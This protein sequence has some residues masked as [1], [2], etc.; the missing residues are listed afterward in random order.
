MESLAVEHLPRRNSNPQ[1]NDQSPMLY[2]LSDPVPQ[3]MST[4]ED[5]HMAIPSE[6][7]QTMG[8]AT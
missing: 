3:L 5:L 7:G 2:H 6:H 4:V 1:P 8:Q